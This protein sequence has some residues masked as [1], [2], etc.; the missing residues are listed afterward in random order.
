[1]TAAQITKKRAKIMEITEITKFQMESLLVLDIVE[2]ELCRDQNPR[3]QKK[4]QFIQ[5]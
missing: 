4:V 2:T 1:M 3:L 5:D